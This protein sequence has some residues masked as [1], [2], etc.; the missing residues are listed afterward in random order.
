M[1]MAMAF[2]WQGSRLKNKERRKLLHPGKKT[3]YGRLLSID[4][5]AL[6]VGIF[7]AFD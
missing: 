5:E 7:S 3:L 4:Y 6:S 1:Q 2:K